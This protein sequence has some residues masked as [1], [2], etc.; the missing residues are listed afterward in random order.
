MLKKLTTNA[1]SSDNIDLSKVIAG[2]AL[3]PDCNKPCDTECKAHGNHNTAVV[4]LYQHN[5]I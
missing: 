1:T 5:P 2:A 3:L 4:A